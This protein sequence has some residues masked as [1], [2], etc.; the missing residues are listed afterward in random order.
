MIL[1]ILI[2]VGL[3]AALAFVFYRQDKLSK[4]IKEL[5]ETSET[6]VTLDDWEGTAQPKIEQLEESDATTRR[7]VAMLAAS[8]RALERRKPPS[9]EA[10]TPEAEEM[11]PSFREED[12]DD[13]EDA[14]ADAAH[15]E[16]QIQAMLSS[17]ANIFGMG[18]QREASDVH[19]AFAAGLP[20]FAGAPTRLIIST[21]GS[22]PARD[23][24]QPIIEEEEDEIV[25]E[26]DEDEAS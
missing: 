10:A 13:L 3:L 18:R 11:L 8:V 6:Y 16:D 25:E 9:C 7:H 15:A 4:E 14:A 19:A 20:A 24:R 5:R 26:I 22:R 2:V 17:V 1:Q 23:V 12:Q 21:G